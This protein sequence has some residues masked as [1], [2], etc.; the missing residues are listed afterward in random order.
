MLRLLRVTHF[1]LIEELTLEF[2]PGLNVLS[3]ET[4]AGKSLIVDAL[5]LL[6]GARASTEQIRTGED[7]A[8]VEAVFDLS[9]GLPTSAC[10]AS[11]T[12]LTEALT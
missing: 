6:A 12:A 1:A 3:G 8:V 9:P 5:G 7:R 2:H 4:G 11:I 10:S